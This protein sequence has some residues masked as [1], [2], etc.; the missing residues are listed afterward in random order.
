MAAIFNRIFYPHSTLLGKKLALVLPNIKYTGAYNHIA[1]DSSISFLSDLSAQVHDAL[2][3]EC[4][5]TGYT[6]RDN[7]FEV[8]EMV[9]DNILYDQ[10]LV[11]MYFTIVKK[12]ILKHLGINNFLDV[13]TSI[14]LKDS[15][16]QLNGIILRKSDIID[17]TCSLGENQVTIIYSGKY[18]T[19]SRQFQTNSPNEAYNLMLSLLDYKAQVQEQNQEE[20]FIIN[21]LPAI[22]GLCTV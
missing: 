21:I 16:N 11:N 5:G 17:V 2:G 9:F 4:V 6:I 20:H 15:V 22:K 1:F 12:V 18:D 7:T 10:N 13:N 14:I 3:V 8:M 19:E